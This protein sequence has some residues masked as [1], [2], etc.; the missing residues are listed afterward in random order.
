[1]S[2]NGWIAVDLDG[3]L[4]HYDEWRGPEHVGAPIQPMVDR[5]RQWLSEGRDVRIF[6]ARCGPQDPALGPGLAQAAIEAWCLEHI[7][8]VLPITCQKDY[9]MVEQWDDR[10]VQVESNTGRRVSDALAQIET[11]VTAAWEAEIA[12]ERK[13]AGQALRIERDFSL[14]ALKK[15]QERADAVGAES[16]RLRRAIGGNEVDLSDW[17]IEQVENL[18]L[19][20]YRDSQAVDCEVEKR[21]AAE[22]QMG[23]L[24]AALEQII[25]KAG[26]WGQC[27]QIAGKALAAPQEPAQ[28]KET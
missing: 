14:R 11:D 15:V 26:S 19:A 25:S 23:R 5:V 16:K 10:A 20:H 6:T 27:C 28:E 7:G 4:A 17:S 8:A 21:H 2:A 24:T 12:D 22:Q 9:G 1:M 13:R 18:A 3:T